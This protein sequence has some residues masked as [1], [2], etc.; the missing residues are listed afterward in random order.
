[1]FVTGYQHQ[2]TFQRPDGSY[3]A[4]GKRD[5]VGSMWLTSFVVK[6][7]GEAR[8][9]ITVDEGNLRTSINWIVNNQLENGCFMLI[10]NVFHKEMQ[11]NFNMSPFLFVDLMCF[12]YGI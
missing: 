9:L 8:N 12:Y 7:L 3:S 4:F 5:E 1:M 11:V 2:L 6:T 10:G